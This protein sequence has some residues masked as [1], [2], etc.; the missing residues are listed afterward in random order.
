MR[1]LALALRTLGRE[2]RSGEL[3]VLLLALTIAVAA[4]TGVGFLV[5]RIGAAVALQASEVLA[6]DIRLG[7]PQPIPESYIEEAQRRGLRTA[8]STSIVTVVFNGDESQ[9]TNVSAV[10][11][12]YPLRGKLM[13]ADEPFAQG[14]P[15]D[16]IPGPGEVWPASKVLASIGGQVGSEL[17]IGAATF[18][19]TRVLISRP[20]Q[21]GTFADLAPSLI[22]NAADLPA[23]QLIQ[24]G[25]RVSYATLFAGERSAI[26]EFKIWLRENKERRER[27]RDITETSPQ[28]DNAVDRAGRFLSL[29]SLVSVLLC[30]I[31]VAMSARRY[32]HRH[33]DSVALLKTLG[34]TRRFTLSVS[35]FQLLAIALLAAVIGS[36]LG[37]AAQ[38][39]L[40]QIVRGLLNDMELPPADFMPVLLGFL[41]A[42]AVLAGFAL[43]PLLQLSRV[44]TIRVL[45]RDVGPPPPLVVLAFGPAVIAVG[46]LIY[47]TVRDWWLFIGFTVGLV[48]FVGTLAGAGA[49]LVSLAG[50][51]RGS[52]GVTWRYGVANLSRRRADSL[53]QIV[54]FGTGLM[55][56]LLL[57]L[58][59]A[60]L[61]DDWR[62]S[63]PE[64]APNYFFINI[65]PDE[66]DAFVEFLQAQ[67]AQLSRVLPMMRG[68]MTQINRSAVDQLQFKDEDG[69]RFASREQNLTWAAELGPDNRII[70]GR[71]W[72]PE[73]MGKPLV[74]LESGF[75]QSI[76][77]RIGDQLTFDVAGE[78]VEVTVA[79][80]RDVK[81]DSFQPNFFIVF[82]PGVLEGSAGTYLTSAYFKPTETRVLAQLARRFPSVSIFDIDDLLAQVRSVVDRATLAVQSVFIFTLFAGFTVLLAA[83]Q[84][85]R[86]ERRY[87]SAML[88]TLGASRS[89]V[90]RAV[91]AEFATLGVLAGI[92][93]ALGASVAGY[94]V[95]TRILELQYSLDPLV[96]IVGLVGGAAIVAGSGWLATRSVVSQPPLLT[97]RAG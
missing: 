40:L 74:S 25:S 22:M 32:V 63:L 19:V 5:S 16:S 60:D 59:Q 80:I 86:D 92:L 18:K 33:L 9:L 47:W 36:A 43:P 93:A 62:N 56:L 94:F 85:S 46:F 7:S 96:W 28:I 73:D 27:L 91:L 38:Q 75:A 77:A 20:D 24:P 37:F 50:R 95:A 14:Q 21:G 53:V 51:L 17:S 35:L 23:T 12:G 84:A 52:V 1:A 26:D 58:V 65:P 87:E 90:L 2:W 34:A 70:A 83:V 69:E 8:T 45:R 54:A 48:L 89:T 15:A 97:L 61:Q 29:A 67:G 42:I 71:W 3:G 41:T 55:A 57:G 64:N 49:L 82:A 6:A 4:L 72:G 81:W 88:R 44:P 39:W 66:R 30:A 10:T 79:S 78:T 13:V 11:D 68:R 76:G 31:A